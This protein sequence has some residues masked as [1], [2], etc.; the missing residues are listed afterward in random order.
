MPLV[1]RLCFVFLSLCFNQT[2]CVRDSGFKH[3]KN[4][5]TARKI[6]LETV[7][8]SSRLECAQYCGM[9]Q[10]CTSAHIEVSIV[11]K[12]QC[13]LQKDNTENKIMSSP[14]RSLL[15]KYSPNVPQTHDQKLLQP[16][17]TSHL[18]CLEVAARLF[19]LQ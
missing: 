11:T 16:S 14:G 4:K 18:G 8:V 10:N 2:S 13:F 19:W 5:Q 12:T 9:S 3:L 1:H 17:A 15:C 6:I 7:N